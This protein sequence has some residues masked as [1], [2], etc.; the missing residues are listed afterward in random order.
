MLFR[1][2]VH[3]GESNSK[4]STLNERACNGPVMKKRLNTLRMRSLCH[5]AML[6]L[7]LLLLL[8]LGTL[9][10]I[11]NATALDPLHCHST[12]LLI[13]R[14]PCTCFLKKKKEKKSETNI[15]LTSTLFPQT[16]KRFAFSA[17]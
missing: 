6:L 1:F 13:T 12:R 14:L 8:L 15:Y 16:A 17:N 9:N 5:F 11:M 10:S 4:Y 7:R 2:R 3:E